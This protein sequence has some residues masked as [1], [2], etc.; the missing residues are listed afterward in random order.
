MES[1]QTLAIRN[2]TGI[3]KVCPHTEAAENH[4]SLSLHRVLNHFCIGK[5]SI[6]RP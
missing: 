4:Q 6:G 5:V 2:L 3:I 1:C